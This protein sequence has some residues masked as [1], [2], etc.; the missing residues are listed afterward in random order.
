MELGSEEMDIVS[1]TG[2]LMLL[3]Q[4]EKSD[5]ERLIPI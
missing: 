1:A 5:C 3:V 4:E 2:E